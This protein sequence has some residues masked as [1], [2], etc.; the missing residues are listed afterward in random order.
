MDDPSSAWSEPARSTRVGCSI[1]AKVGN[2]AIVDNWIKSIT[3]KATTPEGKM[4]AAQ[5]GS[6][7]SFYNKTPTHSDS[8]EVNWEDWSKRISTKGLVEKIKGNTDALMKE[9]YQADKIASKMSSEPT[10]EYRKIVSL[11][12]V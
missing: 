5:L 12:C 7:I 6:V 10:E 2:V 9:K 1:D 11:L 4:Y 3:N 8:F